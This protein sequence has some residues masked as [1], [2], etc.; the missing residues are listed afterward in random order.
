VAAPAVWAS[1]VPAVTATAGNG[2]NS[3]NGAA[4]R[5]QGAIGLQKI[6]SG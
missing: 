2:G 4:C 6:F 1:P 5:W 3:G